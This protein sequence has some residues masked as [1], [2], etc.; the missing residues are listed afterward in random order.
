M[1]SERARSLTTEP[2]MPPLGVAP[3]EEPRNEYDLYM[4]PTTA[5][6]GSNW[7][8]VS[9]ILRWQS[10]LEL[11]LDGPRLGP[12]LVCHFSD[13]RFH[14]INADLSLPFKRATFDCVTLNSVLERLIAAK[15]GSAQQ[16]LPPLFS[17][18]RRILRAGGCL[19]VG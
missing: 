19:Y 5:G 12:D 10:T 8:W 4:S 18:C 17:E 6:A 13:V 11:D 2:A 3:V 16:V 14:A 1:A 7:L 9:E 15:G